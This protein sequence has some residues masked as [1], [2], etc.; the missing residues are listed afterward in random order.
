MEKRIV[1]KI[2]E[3]GEIT[4]KTDGFKGEACIDEL[5]KLLEGVADI[6][7]VKKTDDYYQKDLVQ[8]KNVVK[9]GRK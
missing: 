9:R 5:Q 3:N 6:N 8:N 1:V 7:K 2:D 4:A